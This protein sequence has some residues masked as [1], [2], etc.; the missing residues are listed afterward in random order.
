MLTKRIGFFLGP[1]L[2]LILYLLVPSGFISPNAYKVIAVAAWMISWWVTESAPFPVTALIPL[3]MFPLLGVMPMNQAAAPYANPIIFL[4]M[5]GFFIALALEKHRLHERIALNIIRLTGTSGNGII[6]GF[7]ISTAFISMW[8]SN[9][10]TAMMMLPIALS[11]VKLIIPDT[12]EIKEGEHS[13]ERNFA[14]G[15]MLVVGY[16]STLGGLATIIG[17]PPN[18]VFVGLLNTFNGQ[19]ISFGDWML[20]GVPVMLAL[21][22]GNYF[23]V[24]RILFPNKLDKIKGSDELISSK[25][26]EIG[27]LRKEEK[28][29]MI[30]F[31]TTSFFWIFQE[32][33]NYWVGSDM[34]NDTNIAMA[35]G[36]LMFIVPTSVKNLT[37]LLEWRDTKNMAWGILILFGGGLC[38]AE[39][40][41][42]TGII[43][44]IGQWIVSQTDYNIW[45]MLIL[46]IISVAL[47]EMMSNVA[48]VNIFVPVI[49]GIAQGLN[50]NPIMLA[51]PVTLS[52]SIGFMFPIATPPNAIVFSSGYI[53][54]KDMMRA[55]VLLNIFSIIIIW[56]ASLTL[57]K[58]VFG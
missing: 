12:T 57:V 40:L 53:R 21:L 9:T 22:A 3:I 55:G 10:A 47:S 58:W 41:N 52:A 42:K 7:T 19:K 36:L 4:F 31:L 46:I 54:I 8:I 2:F 34:L 27:S 37:F 14:L 15:L 45:F 6:L 35:G 49:F 56:I 32:A 29:V 5:G 11:V 13:P 30:I 16:A 26:K 24:T 38:L 20:M 23:I 50:I 44:S 1:V 17:T 33:I 48:L 43:Q 18:V 39:G 25:L 28:F 51:L